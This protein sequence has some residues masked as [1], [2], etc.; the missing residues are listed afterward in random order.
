MNSPKFETKKENS[1]LIYL[2]ALNIRV[3]TKWIAMYV[4]SG[5]TGLT[6]TG[7]TKSF[8]SSERSES[9]QFTYL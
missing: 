5:S 8:K 7:T 6:A 4:H 1:I 3:I 9:T 2:S